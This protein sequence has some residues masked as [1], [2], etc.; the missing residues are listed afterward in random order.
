M[1]MKRTNNDHLNLLCDIGELTNLLVGSYSID[2][3]LQRSTKM[4]ARYLDAQV[5]SIYLYDESNQELVLS[6]TTGL[7]PKA[8]GKVR[9][10]LGEG[11]VGYCLKQS[12]PVCDGKA[13]SN[14]H[15]KYFEEAD[16]APFKSF[17]V[18]PIHRGPV[19][20]GA[21]VVEHELPDYFNDNDVTALRAATSQ[22]ASSI[23]NARLLMEI[24]SED[25][26]IQSIHSIQKP[27]LVKAT[28][29]AKGYAYAPA[30]IFRKNRKFELIET[31]QSDTV[32]SPQD[33]QHALE[34]T[35][36]QLQTLQEK[37]AQRLP[38]SASLI[39]TTHFMMLK[40]PSF[41]GKMT[42]LIE[43]GIP[44]LLAVSQVAGHYINLFSASSHGYIRE[45]A[46]DVEDLSLRIMHNMK[47][48]DYKDDILESKSIVIA[49]QLYPSDILKLVAD[50]VQGIILFGGGL[51]SHISLL[52][53]SL[54]IPLVITDQPEIMNLEDYTPLLIDAHIGNIYINPSRHI[55]RRFEER[56]RAQKIARQKNQIM[57][58]STITRDGVRVHLMANINL[59]SEVSLAHR[60][61]AEGIGLYRT[62]FPFLIRP[63]FP[64]E[65]EQ[66]L[67]YKQLFEG[68]R[69]RPVT[70]RTLDVG[71][72]KVLSYLD[73]QPDP[74]P[75]LG[76]RSIRFTLQ[77]RDIFETQIRAILRAALGASRVGIMFPMISSVDQFI[78]SRQV[79]YN[80]MEA[81][82]RE[83]LPFYDNPSI[84]MMVELP[85]VLEIMDELAK[86]ADFFSIGTND[87]VQYMLAVDRTNHRVS[88]YYCA[89]HPSV[90]RGLSR[91][92]DVAQQ[93][94]RDISVCGEMAHIPEYIPFLLGIGIKQLS[95]DPMFLPLVQQNI[96]RIST[97]EAEA[98]AEALLAQPTIKGIAAVMKE[99][100]WNK[101]IK[102]A[103]RID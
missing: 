45:K 24:R 61:K 8:V 52:S 5:C 47:N 85:C 23:E 27:K 25:N 97:S 80:C 35:T 92:V 100:K 87:F 67:V 4:I 21:L 93:K 50:D 33:F 98:Y 34:A 49:S 84:G 28:V 63:N 96:T 73:A 48:P 64:S 58:P 56:N 22:L 29:A 77:H 26:R 18:V 57:Q 15:F 11:I 60:L 43:Q 65:T 36:Q 88:E 90:L 83:N 55:V 16:E 6:A 66:Y 86:E 99:K 75:E 89:H 20:I 44:P 38:E 42:D 68:M 79:V 39:F 2:N 9:M 103:K 94:G 82:S 41:S 91:I 40:D 74:N 78:E 32:Y 37:F 12:S 7:N 17:L 76:L 71:G 51:T 19:K 54:H 81:L 102:S 69:D 13:L 72:E 10:K 3:F 1:V 30:R 101:L 62:E 14:P 95:I 31:A 53:R 70:V 59:L 46:N